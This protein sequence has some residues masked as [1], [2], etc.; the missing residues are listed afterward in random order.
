MVPDSGAAPRP[1]ALRAL[2]EPRR[3]QV[4]VAD[5]LPVAVVLQRT[6]HRVVT[7]QDRWIIEDEWWREDPV[8]RHYYALLLDD[9]RLC[10]VYHDRH[11]DRWYAQGY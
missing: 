11:R 3:L 6:R 7:I 4:E 9:G 8:S 5:G 1:D 2:N 10:T